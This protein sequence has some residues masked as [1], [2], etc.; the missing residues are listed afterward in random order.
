M[1]TSALNAI[2]PIIKPLTP[3]RDPFT[4]RPYKSVRTT[5]AGEIVW[6]S[7][8][9]DFERMEN[10]KTERKK[11]DG[12]TL[13]RKGGDGFEYVVWNKPVIWKES[14]FVL[15]PHPQGHVR[16]HYRFE[17]TQ[18]ER[19]REERL[20]IRDGF[21]D[22]LVNLATSRGLSAE[23][24]LEAVTARDTAL[25]D[26]V[27]VTID[28]GLVHETTR[29]ELAGDPTDAYSDEEVE[30]L[31]EKTD[32]NEYQLTDGTTVRGKNKAIK[33]QRE[34]IAAELAE[35]DSGPEF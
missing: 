5:D 12:S 23:E 2:P 4:G 35:N 30:A 9:L 29:G 3:D 11:P 13:I 25:E 16:K 26:D 10:E 1:R 33:A 27:E 24:L 18:E 8:E 17:P 28:G 34:I 22:E 20:R 21:M 14:Y 19:Q 32:T 6:M 31:L 7:H 15:R